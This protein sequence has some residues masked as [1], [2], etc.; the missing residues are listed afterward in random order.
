MARCSVAF[1]ASSPSGSSA[2]LRRPTD[3][4]SCGDVAPAASRRRA[5]SSDFLGATVRKLGKG[6]GDGERYSSDLQDLLGY[7]DYE[8]GG[9]AFWFTTVRT[10]SPVASQHLVLSK[11]LASAFVA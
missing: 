3:S 9:L 7:L 2:G 8:S 5:F 4:T 11:R 10:P 6:V 1:S